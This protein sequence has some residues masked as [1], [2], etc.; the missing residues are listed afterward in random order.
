MVGN[1]SQATGLLPLA[2]ARSHPVA[3]TDYSCLNGPAHCQFQEEH[4]F[5]QRPKKCGFAGGG[6]HFGRESGS[7]DSAVGSAVLLP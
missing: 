5:N 6:C 7:N 3:N 2:P 1:N 4:F